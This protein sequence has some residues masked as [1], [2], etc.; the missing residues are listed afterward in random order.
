MPH[1]QIPGYYF[2]E[3]D[4]FEERPFWEDVWNIFTPQTWEW[5]EVSVDELW[6]IVRDTVGIPDVP[7]AVV[8]PVVISEQPVAVLPSGLEPGAGLPSEIDVWPEWSLEPILETRPGL[9]PDP[10]PGSPAEA[11]GDPYATSD[12]QQDDEMTDTWG[13]M[14]RELVGGWLGVGGG[15]ERPTVYNPPGYLGGPSGGAP[16]TPG[17]TPP[18][19][20]AAGGGGAMCY[21]SRTGKW[22]VHGRHRRRRLLTESD[23]NDL[24]RIST[25]PNKDTVKVA[26][27]KAIGG[28]H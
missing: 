22:F 21:N 27:A 3:G 24:M 19:A 26:L 10:Y 20:P 15:V 9:P 14:G 25:L 5:P 11:L 13:H 23:F 17:V 4:P 2:P 7:G 8:P 18:G 16:A 1:A 12:P 28:R 6:D